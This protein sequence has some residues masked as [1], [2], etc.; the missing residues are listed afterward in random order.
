MMD[1][2]HCSGCSDD[3]YN[4]HNDLGVS[5]CWSLK[6]AKLVWRIPIGHW[7][8]PPYKN[9]RKKRVPDCWHGRGPYRTHYV[10]PDRLTSDGYWR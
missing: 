2:K 7:E 3:F 1:K 10:N 9:K 5:Q 6:S 8:S 4:G